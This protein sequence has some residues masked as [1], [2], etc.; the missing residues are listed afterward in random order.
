MSNRQEGPRPPEEPPP[1]AVILGMMWTGLLLS[2]ALHV[3]AELNIADQLIAGPRSPA[4]LAKATGAN[5]NAVRRLLRMLASHG[6]FS[7]DDD[8]CFALTTL[9]DVLRPDVPGSV[10]TQ[11]AWWTM[12]TGM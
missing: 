8:G 9:A 4:D 7:E 6:V 11:S 12:G 3:A 10:R 2:R 5:E 1:Q